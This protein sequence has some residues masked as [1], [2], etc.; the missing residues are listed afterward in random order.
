MP[1]VIR[2][3]GKVKAGSTSKAVVCLTDIFATVAEVLGQ[4]A[5]E[6]A[7]DSQ[8]FLPVLLGRSEQGRDVIVH[9]AIDG[10][11]AIRQGSWKLI[12]L[13][14]PTVSATRRISRPSRADQRD[15]SMTSRPIQARQTTCGSRS[16]QRW[17][18]SRRC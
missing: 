7:E 8:S 3:P 17:R 16:P 12:T 6:A 1:F 4:N 5:P 14:V 11:F 10:T 9:H 13:L 18:R 2:W 15:S